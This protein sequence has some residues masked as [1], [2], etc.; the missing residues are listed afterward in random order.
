MVVDPCSAAASDPL[1]ERC[2][3]TAPL[4]ASAN[5]LTTALAGGAKR[6]A[7]RV[8]GRDYDG[9]SLISFPPDHVFFTEGQSVDTLY[10]VLSGQVKVRTRLASGTPVLRAVFGASD[11]FGGL[12]LL[13]PGPQL[14]C[15]TANGPVVVVAVDLE[16][17]PKLLCRQPE[18]GD[19]MLRMLAQRMRCLDIE[20][21][22]LLRSD[23]A[24]RVAWQLTRLAQRFGRPV[25]GGLLVDHGLT[26]AELGRL[27]CSSRES[28]NKAMIGFATR[29]WVR[30]GNKCIVINEPQRLARR[31]Q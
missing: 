24:G 23:V 30:L 11:V 14:S 31:G 27:V 4:P 6:L 7:C 25:P 19:T 16:L 26:Q 15:A 18:L 5:L 17:M 28:V 12:S 3:G 2:R 13:D 29:G 9:I 22:T 20:A 8:V 21:T 1:S 10:V